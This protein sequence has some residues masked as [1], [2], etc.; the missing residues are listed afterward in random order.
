MKVSNRSVTGLA[1]VEFERNMNPKE[2]REWSAPDI[3]YRKH[4]PDL[5][6]PPVEPA[7]DPRDRR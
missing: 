7:L 1:H 4:Y 5:P 2:G 3:R 6:I